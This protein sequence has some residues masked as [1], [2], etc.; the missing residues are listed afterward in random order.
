MAEAVKELRTPPPVG[1]RRGI[2]QLT[3]VRAAV[4]SQVFEIEAPAGYF[5]GVNKLAG[6]LPKDRDI[7]IIIP[8]SAML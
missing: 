4:E 1:L 6:Q 8:P 3:L 7:R 2:G 5:R